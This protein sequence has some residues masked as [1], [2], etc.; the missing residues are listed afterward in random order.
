MSGPEFHVETE[1]TAA[2]R[3]WAWADFVC[4]TISDSNIESSEFRDFYDNIV[5]LRL[6]QI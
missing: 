4:L 3:H 1:G 6:T 2:A 5:N